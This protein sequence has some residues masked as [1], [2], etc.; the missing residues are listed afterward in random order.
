MTKSHKKGTFPISNRNI[1]FL[2]TLCCCF[3]TFYN[4]GLGHY[5]SEFEPMTV[6]KET[7]I[8]LI[9]IGRGSIFIK[10]LNRFGRNNVIIILLYYL[11]LVIIVPFLLI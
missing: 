3:K 10:L 4:Q 8:F 9:I 6:I 1:Y 5:L 7:H 2:E 11:Y